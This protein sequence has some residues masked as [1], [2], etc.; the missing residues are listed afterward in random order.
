MF[1]SLLDHHQAVI[2]TER[3]NLFELSNMDL[4]LVLHLHITELS[5]D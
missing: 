3:L 2:M 4:Y 1:R 5:L